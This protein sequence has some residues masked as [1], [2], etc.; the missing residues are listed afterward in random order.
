VVLSGAQWCS[1]AGRPIG[2]RV[3]SGWSAARSQPCAEGSRTQREQARQLSSE[4]AWKTATR[5]SRGW[6]ER[7]QSGNVS[8]HIS[9]WAEVSSGRPRYVKG[10]PES[11]FAGPYGASR[12]CPP[13][14]PYPGAGMIAFTSRDDHGRTS[15]P[16]LLAG[17]GG[18][19]PPEGDLTQGIGAGSQP[20]AGSARTGSL[21]SGT[22]TRDSS[23]A[24]AA[25]RAPAMSRSG[26]RA[27]V[28]T[29]AC[30]RRNWVC[31]RTASR[32]H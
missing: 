4:W 13:E 16:P 24:T 25:P 21:R 26:T 8:A 11:I 28:A 22:S 3:I 30:S 17:C 10:Y 6:V 2:R 14:P 1:A 7:R 23:A 20:G 12:A 9:A 31:S 18:R 29:A 27:K 5:R 19:L 15:G 32:N